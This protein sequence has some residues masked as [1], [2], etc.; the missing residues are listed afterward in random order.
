MGIKF[1]ER[2][3]VCVCVCVSVFCVRGTVGHQM[4]GAPIAIVIGATAHRLTDV[5]WPEA[6]RIIAD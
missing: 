1:D 3:C 2:L 5:D 4:S 6:T